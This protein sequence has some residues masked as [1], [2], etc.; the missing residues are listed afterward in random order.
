MSNKLHNKLS[1]RRVPRQATEW[2]DTLDPNKRFTGIFLKRWLS[3]GITELDSSCIDYLQG[4]QDTLYSCCPLYG[5]ECEA[6]ILKD[7]LDVLKKG[8]NIQ[9]RLIEWD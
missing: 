1:F 4:I 8:D 5:N 6:Q 3:K 7:M 9:L 2:V